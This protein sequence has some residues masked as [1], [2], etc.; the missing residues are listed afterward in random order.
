M[1][2]KN[3]LNKLIVGCIVSK[4]KNA[5]FF[6]LYYVIATNFCALIDMQEKNN[7]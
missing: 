1:K 7:K 6:N 3:Q 5:I 2:G 4:K